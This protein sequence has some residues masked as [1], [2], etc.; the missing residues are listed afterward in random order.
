MF[1]DDGAGDNFR[2]RTKTTCTGGTIEFANVS[3]KHISNGNHG[4]MRNDVKREQPGHPA[5]WIFDG[6]DQ[7]I[8]FGNKLNALDNDMILFAWIKQDNS[9]KASNSGIIAKY[10]TPGYSFMLDNS[11]PRIYIHDGSNSR[12]VNG[13]NYSD[14]TW[15]FLVVVHDFDDYTRLY[16]DLVE[17]GTADNTSLSS[18]TSSHILKMGTRTASG[19]FLKGNIGIAGIYIFDG[20]DGAP[21]AL[22]SNHEDLVQFVY[23]NT[24][25]YYKI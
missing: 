14:G 18:I 16:A 3:V 21:S 5:A 19:D 13:G 1:M 8:D 4:M 25:Y 17:I 9:D 23:D 11:Y 12:S 20:Q 2:F 22:P 10:G 24:K 6:V 15:H 7:Y